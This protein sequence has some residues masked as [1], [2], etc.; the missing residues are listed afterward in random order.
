M[1]YLPRSRAQFVL[2]F[3]RAGAIAFAPADKFFKLLGWF[4]S[5]YER[6][7][8]LLMQIAWLGAI[9]VLGFCVAPGFA[10]TISR[11]LDIEASLV[12][13]WSMIGPSDGARN[14][15]APFD[16]RATCQILAPQ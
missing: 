11:S 6:N 15:L 3:E 13:I 8:T 4:M 12:A 5:K 14:W 16:I 1:P 7:I 9:L 10:A 2:G